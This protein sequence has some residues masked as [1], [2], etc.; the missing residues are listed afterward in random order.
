MKTGKKLLALLLAVVMTMSLLTVGAFAEETPS[1]ETPLEQQDSGSGNIPDD[2]AEGPADDLT[3]NSEDGAA[4]ESDAALT[5]ADTSYVAEVDGQQYETLQAAVDAVQGSGTIELTSSI[6]LSDQVTIDSGKTII[7]DMNGETLS[8]GFSDSSKNLIVNNGTLTITGDGT[9]DATEATSY[10]GFINNYGTLTV[11]NGTFQIAD[12]AMTVHLRNQDGGKAVINGGTF[13]GGA[14]IVRSFEGSNTTITGG[15]F[16][17]SVY[18]AVDVNGE[19]LITGG[20]FTN[21][22]CSRCDSQNWGYTVRSGVDN[23]PDAKLTITPSS[24]GSVVVTGTQG[25]LSATAGTMEV[26]GGS[27]KTVDCAQK[28]GAVFY[29]LYVAGE[30]GAV[31]VVVND[32]TFVTEG[33]QTAVLVGNSNDG[34]LKEQA[35]LQIR[36]G[37]FSAP[38][39]IP[40][41]KVDVALGG[42]NITGGTF[43][44]KVDEQYLAEG[45]VQNANGEVG[46]RE[47]MMV[48][49]VTTAEGAEQYTSLAEAVEA[50]A[51]DSVIKLLKDTEGDGIVIDTSQKNLT[52][53]F[54]THSYTVSGSTVGSSGTETNAFQFL[55][56]GSL[57]L[58]NGSIIFA[59][60]KTLLIGLQNYCNLTLENMVID[61]SQASAPCQYAISNNCGTVQFIG[62]T[63]IK[64][65]KN[66]TAFDS[67]KFGSY[68]IPTV[69][70]H[71]TGT[72]TGD[73]ELSGGKLEI[74]AGTFEGNIRTVSGYAEGDAIITGGTFSSDVSEYLDEG[75]GQDANGTVG[76][77]EEGFAAV[78]IG[79]TYYQTLAKAIAEAKENDTITLLREVDLGSD[80]VTINKAVTLD[81]NGCT[82]TS[83]NATNTLWLE[84]SRVTVQDSKGNGKIQNT[85]SGSN[86]IAV[87]VNGQ[88]TE[89][90]FKSGTVS[91]NYAVFIQNGAK[92][93]I[94]GGK[95]TG[96]Y[97]INTV[98]TGNEANKTAVEINGGEIQAVAF[99]VAGNGS[100]DYTET[101]ITGGRLEST[102]GNVIYH[103]QVGDL[104][105]KGDAELIGPNGVQYC[106]AGT[107]TIAENAV[108]T[109]TL[110]FT[111]FPTKPASQ[112]DGSTDDGA[113][114]S[115]VSRGGGY[116]GEG[117]TMTVNITGGTLTSR[118]NAAIAVY[119]LERV[120]GQWTTNEN[121]K[122]AS[123]LAALTV[124]G[125]NFSAGSKKDAFEIDTQAV[126]EI[127]VTGGYFTPD[128]S[129]YV[130][131]NAEPKLF[132]V[133][134][135]KTGY[136]YMVTTT[137]PTEVDPI[138]TEKTETEVSESIEPEDQ[139]K[140]EA[141][142]DNAQVSGVSD[143]V[144]ESA[145]NAI[146]NQ[147]EEALKPEDKVVV[148][149][150]VSLTADKAD[151][152]TEDKMYVSYKAEPVAKVIVNG[153]DKAENIAVPNDYLDGQTLIEVRLPIP[154]DLEPQEIMHIADDGTRERYL[155]GSGF[156]VE[157]GCAVLHVK[158]FSTFVLNGQL[159]VAAKIGE[160]E[161]G[162][163]QEAVNAAK[164]GDTI[165]LTQDCDEK[166]SVSG[167]SVT[168]DLGGYTY[169]KDKITLGSR[170]SMSVS[171]DKITITYSAPSG[172]G[173]SSSSSGD[174]T[175]S[176]E[177]SKHG[178]VTVSPKRADKGDTVTIT[179]KPDNGYE[180]DE[181]TVTDKDGDTVKLQSK[182][183]NK[184]TFT[185][186]GSKV[187]VEATFTLE[188]EENLPFADVAE[189]Y[190]AVEEITWAYENGYMNGVSA[191]R[192]APG[193]TVTRQQLWMV[194]ARLTEF[195]PS[196]MTEAQHWAVESKIS[197]G[198]NPGGALTR[199]Q[200]VTILYRWAQ[201]MGYDVSGRADLSA[202]PDNASVA[203]Y[204]TEPMT[205]A[206]AEGII[207]GT[208]E[209]LLNPAGTATRAQFAVILYR[210]FENVM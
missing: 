17:N 149:I 104:T 191:E 173:S 127:S 113:A 125:G 78:R 126:D 94:D 101:V 160:S 5:A 195:N 103:P 207:S 178:T 130:P 59:N 96:T 147:V 112:G 9:F 135:D 174:Y 32:G 182:G 118:N 119:R 197:D 176:V 7:L 37:Q 83:S 108:I 36:G 22:S 31:Q 177:N 181:L 161:Y 185:M 56:G 30:A 53:D 146:I 105:I 4:G 14:T 175:V 51:N 122:I 203:A 97:G 133:A 24:E 52:I 73:I 165:V 209:G 60:Q 109:A 43:S 58:K 137:K 189:D 152:T 144:T 19:T 71:T 2:P 162:T 18:P 50:A 33:K 77:V 54:N 6:A 142:I 29:A 64:A 167:K 193:S 12:K 34:G 194:L 70:I 39:G 99:A 25:A 151:L 180:L 89:A 79:D 106:G 190:W 166:I 100:A 117:Q 138:V 156:T 170:C 169:N 90:Y 11:E 111:E 15:S 66:Q 198:S 107:L 159:T 41:Y 184:Y 1:S 201:Q 10:K 35:V 123:Y 13:S 188:K 163:L 140:I 61:A 172:G 84:A 132:V 40:A 28:H 72:I 210:F 199:Q 80:R 121:T 44:S 115:V 200:M 116:Q 95:Y 206:I 136:A 75:L 91:G 204:A 183:G 93:V 92:A 63:S 168:I 179:V 55:T 76:K 48:A 192:F 134:S 67:C 81:L 57:T 65:Y 110:P 120:N 158:H 124:S 62:N 8:I 171:D 49:E 20:I 16:T 186:P 150:T 74:S 69:K 23:D 88:D 82:L 87:V 139:K 102:E 205:W 155:N 157:D 46:S 68:E 202:F 128:P 47:E 86:N 187:T 114:L 98:G 153:E 164:S 85:G 21:T 26:N 148:E 208:T 154:V 143:A 141:V 145:Q 3:G 196:N 129:D 131:E 38:E 42:L 27:Y 45:Y